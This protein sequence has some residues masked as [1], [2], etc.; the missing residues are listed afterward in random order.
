MRHMD[1]KFEVQMYQDAS[2]LLDTDIF[3]RFSDSMRRCNDTDLFEV[4]NFGFR[5]N[6]MS[7]YFYINKYFKVGD[8]GPEYFSLEKACALMHWYLNAN[9]NDLSIL[10]AF[11]E[12]YYEGVEEDNF[13][14]ISESTRRVYPKYNSN[15]GYYLFEQRYLLL[16]FDK[17]KNDKNSRQASIS[18]NNNDI[19]YDGS[20]DKLCTNN[21]SFRIRDNKL[22]MTV[23]MRSNDIIRNMVYDVFTFSMVYGIMFNSLLTVYPE[24]TVGEYYHCSASMHMHKWDSEKLV[25]A[26]LN[27]RLITPCVRLKFN[28]YDDFFLDKLRRRVLAV[29]DSTF[30]K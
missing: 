7:Q 12:Y 3:N 5:I 13:E 4:E 8:K 10:K 28:F 2:R 18:I 6:P 16:A 21:I 9:R 22:N 26:I 17:L 14:Q 29:T 20:I 1:K 19:M 15:Y 11:P 23:Q 24:L 25:Y 30:N 27:E